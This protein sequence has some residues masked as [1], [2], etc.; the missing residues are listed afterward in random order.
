[1]NV[2]YNGGCLI[3]RVAKIFREYSIRIIAAAV[4]HVYQLD[5]IFGEHLDRNRAI[6]GKPCTRPSQAVQTDQFE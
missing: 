3:T 2:G 5:V 1:M 4:Q 6:T